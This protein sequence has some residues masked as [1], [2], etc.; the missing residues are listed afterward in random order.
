MIIDDDGQLHQLRYPSPSADIEVTSQMDIDELAG[1]RIMDESISHRV[2][3]SSKPVSGDT[4]SRAA[5]STPNSIS[6]H[7][8]AVGATSFYSSA[9]GKGKDKAKAQSR[10]FPIDVNCSED[11]EQDEVD[12]LLN[13][14]DS[15]ALPEQPM[16][17]SVSTYIPVPEIDPQLRTYI[18][19]LDSLGSRHPQAIKYL[20]TY[21]KMEA[22]DKKNVV[23]MRK[24]GISSPRS[25]GVNE[26]LKPDGNR[27]R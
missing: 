7:S 14:P 24:P 23:P 12:E 17:V 8:G 25:S 1:D 5:S 18:F 2:L 3:T 13:E 21:L 11:G 15:N 10:P 16:W 27:I 19:T 4:D 22:K 9:K 20:R 26:K 6:T